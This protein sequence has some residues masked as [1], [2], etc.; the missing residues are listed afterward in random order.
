MLY[1]F[2]YTNFKEN[3]IHECEVSKPTV[4][5]FNQS[6]REACIN[7]LKDEGQSPI[8]GYGRTVEIDESIMS[9]RKYNRGRILSAQWI[10]AGY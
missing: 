2:G 10:L 9:Q 7:W 5:N 6:F 3:C 1:L 8:G 4:T